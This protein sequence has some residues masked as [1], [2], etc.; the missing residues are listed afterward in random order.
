MIGT[1]LANYK[2]LS[3]LGEGGM[4][5][6]YLAEDQRLGRQVAL[7]V[8]PPETSNDPERLARFEREARVVAGLNHPNIVVLHSVETVEGTTFITMEYVDGK[9]LTAHLRP[10]GLALSQVLT[11][12]TPLADAIASAH[13]QGVTHRDLKPDNIMI[14][15]EGRVKVLDFGLAKLVEADQGGDFDVTMDAGNL[16]TSEGMVL[17]TPAY[18][19]PEQAEGKPV[20]HRTDIFALGIILYQMVTGKRPFEGDTRMSTLTAV[21]RDDPQPVTELV[22]GLPTHLGRVIQRC[23]AKDPDR[24]YQTALDIRNELETISDELTSGASTP[25]Q[26]VSQAP[27]AMPTPT[28]YPHSQPTPTPSAMQ[29]APGL[30]APGEATPYPTPSGQY[31]HPSSQFPAPSSGRPAWLMP[32]LGMV[33]VVVIAAAI[34]FGLQKGESG[35][36]DRAATEATPVSATTN[37][38][39]GDIAS[40]DAAKSVVVFPFENLGAPDDTYFAA[41]ITDEIMSQLSAVKGIN[42]T[43]RTSATQYDRSGKT[44]SDIQGDLGVE[45]ILEGT[46]RWEKSTDGPN[47]VRIAPA[48]VRTSDD[49]QV[50]S[51]RYERPMEDIFGIQSEIASRVV[52][53]LGLT[54]LE[55]ARLSMT[56]RPTDNLDAYHAYLRANELLG[57]ADFSRQKTE[58]AIQVL[59]RAVELDPDFTLAHVSLAKAHSSFCHWNWD[60]SPERLALAKVSLDRVQELAPGSAWADIAEGYYLYWGQKDL[61]PALNALE[62]ARL[63]LPGN[64]DILEVIGFVQRR[65]GEYE[66]AL[67]TLKEAAE[68]DPTNPGLL[69]SV[70]ETASIIYD[71]DTAEA[72]AERTIALAPDGPQG[73]WAK[74]HALF[75]RGEFEEGIQTILQRPDVDTDGNWNSGTA[76]AYYWAGDLEKALEYAEKGPEMV[77]RQFRVD[78]RSLN[79]ANIYTELGNQAEARTHF[80]KALT[81]LEA[82]IEK[83]PNDSNLMSALG[84]VHARLG[85]REQALQF[86]KDALT[87]Y[88]A[89]HDMYIRASRQF[90]LVRTH[91]F[92]GNIDEALETLIDLHHKKGF[93]F[94]CKPVLRKSPIFDPLRN[95]P[96]FK[97]LLND[98]T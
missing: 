25:H 89:S 2:I 14:N 40:T 33:G 84:I 93:A 96:D 16:A 18:M 23:L 38:V 49:T 88:P 50:W 58:I 63:K 12:A 31:A 86:A 81:L 36:V 80:L 11:I 90:D 19:S 82:E 42:V 67:T 56:T 43:S 13:K 91:M 74:Y 48:L 70:S 72:Y 92:L 47:R 94:V 24:R 54:L 95:H 46:V 29:S 97:K 61:E 69:Y 21:I 62:Q 83:T 73:Y 4:G 26:G 60:R 77:L 98:P 10:E 9:P 45:Y 53:E 6:V 35:S 68:R 85:N 39:T 44:A 76:G 75:G 57:S 78:S 5:T 65:K 52:Q 32:V 1:T 51:D 71:F 7:K 41:G 8:V 34:F 17:G 30:N 20:D 87:A 66:K 37:S 59:N 3:K 22:G 64:V 79:L 27:G 15:D 55:P 28:S